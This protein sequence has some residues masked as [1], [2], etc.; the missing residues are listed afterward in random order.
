MV[1]AGM[2]VGVLPLQVFE[3]MG[4]Q[5]GL[6]AVPLDEDWAARSLVIV[7]RDSNALS[8][9]SRL[10]FDHLASVESRA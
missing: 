10:L 3:A 7:V 8:P 6:A 2:G 9:V 5:L 4:R 1:Q